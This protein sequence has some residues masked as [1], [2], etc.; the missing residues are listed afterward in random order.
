MSNHVEM[1]FS[2]GAVAFGATTAWIPGITEAQH[3]YD[4]V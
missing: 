1:A 4:A 3:V 2:F